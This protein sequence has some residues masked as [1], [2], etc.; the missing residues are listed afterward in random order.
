MKKEKWICLAVLWMLVTALCFTFIRED[1][2][3]QMGWW[4]Y[5]GWQ[6][7]EGKVLYKD[8]FCYLPPGYVW[9]MAGLYQFLGNHVL[10][11]QYLGVPLYCLSS[12]F[13]YLILCRVASPLISMVAVFAG[14]VLCLSYPLFVA[15]DYNPTITVMIYGAAYFCVLGVEKKSKVFLFL[16]GVLA[17]YT[18]LM[19]QI[20]PFFY[21]GILLVLI[22]GAILQMFDWKELFRKGIFVVLGMA[23]ILS[24]AILYIDS[25]GA[26]PYMANQLFASVNSKGYSAGSLALLGTIFSRFYHMGF[27]WLEFGIAVILF[28]LLFWKNMPKQLYGIDSRQIL[29]YF[30][31][32]LF[33]AKFIRIAVFFD[34]AWM[35]QYTYIVFGLNFL[36]WAVW[37]A[38]HSEKCK[39]MVESINQVVASAGTRRKIVMFTVSSLVIG[40]VC[41]YGFPWNQWIYAHHVTNRILFSA[42]AVAFY[43][44]VIWCVHFLVEKVK[45]RKAEKEKGNLENRIKIILFYFIGA[46]VL[47]E[48]TILPSAAFLEV[49]FSMP[50]VA[51]LFILIMNNGKLFAKGAVVLFSLLC[52]M[53]VIGQKQTSAYD[54]H[55]FTMDGVANP[56]YE[57]V[58]SRVSGMEGARLTTETEIGYE[59]ITNAIYAYSGE[60]DKVY[61]FPNFTLFNCL[62]ERELGTFAVS[63]YMDVC[64]DNILLDDLNR[65]KCHMPEM[66]IWV[67]V[68]E[69]SWDLNEKIFRGGRLS[70]SRD[71]IAFYRGTI[72]KEY[73]LVYRFRNIYV[74][75]KEPNTRKNLDL[76]I[77][78]LNSV[79]YYYGDDEM[80]GAMSCV[81]AADYQELYASEIPYSVGECMA[82]VISHTPEL[83]NLLD[84]AFYEHLI[85]ESKGEKMRQLKSTAVEDVDDE[86]DK[87]RKTS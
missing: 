6:M 42:S 40:L 31:F 45:N 4:N 59:N 53:T 55:G 38:L 18:I 30:L 51:F 16:A 69:S 60:N 67:E 33:L 17:G 41:Y 7:N 81:S 73:S 28:V 78:R 48:S 63:H 36:Y 2:P 71:M 10:W 35:A 65:I 22:I 34:S 39:G 82:Y 5:Y 21:M 68:S 54:W 44:S 14:S 80:K 32:N 1:I 74:W 50:T 49:V 23:F 58:D 20:M 24:V 25:T 26:L 75:A 12:T 79:I 11:Y 84:D 13:V 43:F 86:D 87:E 83:D 27:S 9:M 61:E 72:K 29:Y 3:P 77:A 56:A 15:F 37:L 57:Y 46:C 19:K 70:A 66:F 62:T 52:I 47:W 85:P 8:V 76:A 64:P